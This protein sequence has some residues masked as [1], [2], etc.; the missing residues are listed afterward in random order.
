[1][2]CCYRVITSSLDLDGIAGRMEA[3]GTHLN[4]YWKIR[5][6]TTLLVEPHDVLVR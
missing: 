4:V 2:P 6:M 5:Y 1:M 3:F